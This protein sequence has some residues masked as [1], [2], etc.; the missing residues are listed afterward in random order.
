[1]RFE[2][3]RSACA[4]GCFFL[5]VAVSWASR[6][7]RAV[8][9]QA[10]GPCMRCMSVRRG[11]HLAA[12]DDSISVPQLGPTVEELE[13]TGVPTQGMFDSCLTHHGPSW[14]DPGSGAQRQE[15]SISS[16]IEY[17]VYSVHETPGRARAAT[18]HASELRSQNIT[19]AT[20]NIYT[21]SC[22]LYFY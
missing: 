14:L 9:G 3:R 13:A 10:H 4:G 16:C 19:D 12:M 7:A 1:M 2:D 15:T 22:T 20:H 21:A 6:S 17:S 5:A 8:C 11:Q 18:T